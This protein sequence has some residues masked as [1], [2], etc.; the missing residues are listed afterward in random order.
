M[1]LKTLARALLTLAPALVF[2]AAAG[3]ATVR[4]EEPRRGGVLRVAVASEPNTL[5]CHAGTTFT[6]VHHLAPHYSFLVKFD[7]AN[8]PRVIGDLA[9]SWTISPDGLTYTF[10][11]HDGVLFHDGTRLTSA[12]GCGRTMP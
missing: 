4:A 12:D 2:L 8:Y 1:K 10:R 6:V 5:D 3:A 11:L 9:E 7:A